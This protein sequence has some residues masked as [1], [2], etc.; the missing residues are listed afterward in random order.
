MQICAGLAEPW[1]WPQGRHAERSSTAVCVPCTECCVR[2]RGGIG[3]LPRW[4]PWRVEG[5]SLGTA[6]Q[7]CDALFVG[8]CLCCVLELRRCGD[9]RSLALWQEE[10]CGEVC[11]LPENKNPTKDAGK[12][13]GASRPTFLVRFGGRPGPLRLPK[14]M[15]SG[16]GRDRGC[17]CSGP[18]L[19]PPAGTLVANL[20]NL[21]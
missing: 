16:S 6:S 4:Q 17:K 18:G 11:V 19:E 7:L 13:L 20:Q 15:I 3:G 14:S 5:C 21:G 2:E 12:R 9:R 8:V 1:A 10:V